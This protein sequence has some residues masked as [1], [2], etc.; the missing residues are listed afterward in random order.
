MAKSRSTISFPVQLQ[1]AALLPFYP[2]S[3]L[4]DA[5]KRL[6]LQQIPY[7]SSFANNHSGFL[8]ILS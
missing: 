8:Y 2:I 1:L 7:Y 5:S 6:L 3:F 4:C